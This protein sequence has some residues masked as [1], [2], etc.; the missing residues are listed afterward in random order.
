MDTGLAGGLGALPPSLEHCMC[1]SVEFLFNRK[2]R[3]RSLFVI[4]HTLYNSN[5]MGQSIF[6]L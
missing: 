4:P 1:F 5:N 6:I 3:A 2:S